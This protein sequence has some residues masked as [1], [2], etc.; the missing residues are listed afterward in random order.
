M[1]F[2][3]DN[4]PVWL[5]LLGVFFFAVS[6]SLLAARKQIDIVGSLLLASLVGLGGG[7]IRDVILVIVPAAFTNPAYLAPPLLATVLVFFLF[8]SVQRYTSLLVLF[9]AAG[10]ALFC[11]TGTLKALATGLNPVASVLLGV[12]T[13]VG[14]GLLRDITANEVPEL[15]NPK[16]IYALPAFVGSS[17]TAVL[18]VLGVFNVLTAAG[19]AA[20]VF[21]FRVLAWRRSWQAPLAVRGWQRRAS[22]PGL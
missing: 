20:L 7:V 15:F 12:T 21:T 3:F 6:G 2:A 9:D 11:M 8:S 17:L 22:D 19:I 18:W 1:T 16:D 13:A 5:D 10:L 14:G 4:S